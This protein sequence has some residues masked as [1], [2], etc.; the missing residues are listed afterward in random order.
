MRTS[1]P[2][3]VHA[4][5]LAAAEALPSGAKRKQPIP[6]EQYMQLLVESVLPDLANLFPCRSDRRGVVRVHPYSR[7]GGVASLCLPLLACACCASLCLPPATRLGTHWQCGRG[8]PAWPVRDS[9]C[10]S[11]MRQ[12]APVPAGR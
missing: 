9:D 10:A 5:K 4:C 12:L 11:L 2:Q 1:A 7:W 3:M 8:A 6:Q